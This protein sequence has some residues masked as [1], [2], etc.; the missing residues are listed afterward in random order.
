M[1]SQDDGQIELAIEN[2]AIL[3]GLLFFSNYKAV[4]IRFP[5]SNSHAIPIHKPTWLVA[6]TKHEN[7]SIP[8]LAKGGWGD[9]HI[10]VS[11]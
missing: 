2:I 5:F 11:S 8:P 7:P 9:F 6:T 4:K 10:N 1:T 3:G